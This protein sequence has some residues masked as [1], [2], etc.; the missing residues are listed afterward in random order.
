MAH[1]VTSH[2]WIP[3]TF[4]SDAWNSLLGLRAF[5]KLESCFLETSNFNVELMSKE[6]L[7]FAHWGQFY[8]ISLLLGSLEVN[9]NISKQDEF[10]ALGE[11]DESSLFLEKVGKDLDLPSPIWKQ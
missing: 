1:K 9:K 5:I 11:N 8:L 2:S 4:S 10:S 3:F 7:S 6:S